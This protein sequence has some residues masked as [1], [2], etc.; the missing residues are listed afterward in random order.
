MYWNK[1]ARKLLSDKNLILP[2]FRRS[3]RDNNA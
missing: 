1:I 2:P 3:S